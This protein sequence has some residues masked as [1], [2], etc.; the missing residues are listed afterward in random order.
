MP[1]EVDISSMSPGRFRSVLSP[2]RFDE[3]ARG[4]DEARELLAG[5]GST[6][7]GS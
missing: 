5:P 3:F 1:I 2:E 6:R 7:A 4:L